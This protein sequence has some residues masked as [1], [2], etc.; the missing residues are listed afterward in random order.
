MRTLRNILFIVLILFMGG[1]EVLIYW[2]NHLYYRAVETDNNEEKIELLNRTVDFYPVNDLVYAERGKAYFDLGVDHIAD[3]AVSKEYLEESINNYKR[4][5]RSNPALSLT[6]FNLAQSLLYKSYLFSTP[7]IE[8]HEEFIKAAT[9]AGENSYV[10]Y[11]VSKIFLSRWS[12]LSDE[13]KDFTADIL[14]KIMNKDDEEKIRSLLHIW[15]MN[16]KDYNMIKTILPERAGVYR[17]YADF[18]GEKS[19]S[20]E[21]RQRSLAQAEFYEFERAREKKKEGD[22]AFFS[23]QWDEAVKHYK[24]CLR[25]LDKI[26]FYQNLIP[27]NPIDLPTFNE[28]KKLTILHLAK[29]HIDKGSSFKDYEAYLQEYLSLEDDMP[30]ILDLESYLEEK[31]LLIDKLEDSFSDLDR[32]A[33]RLLF[34]FKKNRY[35]EIMRIGRRLQQSFVIIPKGKERAY[36]RISD[37]IGDAYRKNGHVFE[38]SEFYRKSL[39]IEPHSLQTLIRLRSNYEKLGNDEM[40]RQIEE[41]TAAVIFSKEKNFKNLSIDKNEAFSYS[42]ILD[43]RPSILNIQFDSGERGINPLISVF[44]N[45]RIIWED[46]LQEEELLLPVESRPGNNSLEIIPVNRS[47]SLVKLSCQRT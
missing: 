28:I 11:E 23:F 4:A 46:Y 34:L 20:L 25:I 1:V 40:V 42:L 12:F 31:G 3:N 32:M 9:L 30:S 15:E 33:F 45:G 5:L 26:K 19:L 8:A 18:L 35:K 43:D 10:F 29:C 13:E 36:R 17:I 44:F 47:I 22:E 2:N 41:R 39:E 24:S 38:A 16:I 37:L 6:H 14:R 7:N 21:E 27:E